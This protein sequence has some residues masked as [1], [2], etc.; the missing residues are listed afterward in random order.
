MA[1]T[2]NFKEIDI[3]FGIENN[4]FNKK[5]NNTTQI[6]SLISYNIFFKNFFLSPNIGYFS[7]PNTILL[8][9]TPGFYYRGLSLGIGPA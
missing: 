3:S 9:L 4:I 7:Q 8:A 1:K 5:K 6:S 2:Y